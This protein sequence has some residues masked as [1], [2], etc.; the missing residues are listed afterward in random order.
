MQT[1]PSQDQLNRIESDLQQVKELLG[2]LVEKIT[3]KEKGEVEEVPN[4]YF[5]K[6]LEEAREARKQGKASPI[7]D[8]AEEMIAWLHKQGV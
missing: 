1:A 6:A 2:F 3:V 8:T 7:F 4:E 5:R